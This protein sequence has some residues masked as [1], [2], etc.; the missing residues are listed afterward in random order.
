M[1]YHQTD[2][3]LERLA[4]VIPFLLY[5]E[6]FQFSMLSVCTGHRE[7][8]KDVCDGKKFDQYLW[9][10]EYVVYIS[11]NARHLH[12]LSPV[13]MLLTKAVAVA[14]SVSK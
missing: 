6:Y 3:C 11:Q 4:V 10:R 2:S 14:L 5:I 9:A 8:P 12:I 13:W 1:Q 7:V